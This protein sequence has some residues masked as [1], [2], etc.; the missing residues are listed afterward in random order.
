MLLPHFPGAHIPGKGVQ[1]QAAVPASPRPCQAQK[2]QFTSSYFGKPVVTLK[3]LC[4]NLYQQA[5]RKEK[6]KGP[7]T[8][9]PPAQPG[10]E[11]VVTLWTL[12]SA[13]QAKL[14]PQISLC[15]C[16]GNVSCPF[17]TSLPAMALQ[18][19]C[20]SLPWSF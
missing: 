11:L 15:R 13:I 18:L 16:Q 6:V 12:A 8:K 2:G 10:D 7:T 3:T 14:N 20:T 17:P 1:P 5:Q 4:G 19:I 9:D